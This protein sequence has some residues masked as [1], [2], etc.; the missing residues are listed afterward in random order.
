MRIFASV[1]NFSLFPKPFK[2]TF[3]SNLDAS[4]NSKI[5]VMACDKLAQLQNMI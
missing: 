3:I 1:S 5:D 2:F 4:F